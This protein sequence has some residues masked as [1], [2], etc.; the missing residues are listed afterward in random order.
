VETRI[1]VRILAEDEILL[2]G[3]AGDLPN[4][5]EDSHGGGTEAGAAASGHQTNCVVTGRARIAV[6]QAIAEEI[7][8]SRVMAIRSARQMMLSM[9]ETAVRVAEHGPRW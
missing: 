2:V 1:A 5:A 9:L 6:Q 7:V 4:L 3:A 8:A